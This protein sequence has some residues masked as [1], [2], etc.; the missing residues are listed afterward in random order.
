MGLT[1]IMETSEVRKKQ[2]S[3]YHEKEREKARIWL[4]TDNSGEREEE[5]EQEEKI[6]T[7]LQ[8]FNLSLIRIFPHRWKQWID[9]FNCKWQ[10]RDKTKKKRIF[11]SSSLD[12]TDASNDSKTAVRDS[13]N[14]NE[15]AVQERLKLKRKLQRNRTSFS[16]EQIDALEQGS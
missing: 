8:M 12:L 13:L 3:Y 9:S 4:D 5:E 16:Q 2:V 7:V 1:G 11:F 14:E 10:D 15:E 6:V